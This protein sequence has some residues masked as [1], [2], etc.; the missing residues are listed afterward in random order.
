MKLLVI[1]HDDEYCIIDEKCYMLLGWWK[2]WYHVRTNELKLKWKEMTSLKHSKLSYIPVGTLYY[3]ESQSCY[4]QND[5]LRGW[6]CFPHYMLYLELYSARP[7]ML[8]FCYVMVWKILVNKL[9]IRFYMAGY[10]I[11]NLE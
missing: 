4:I 2:L 6:Y 3:C 1:T 5:Y 7:V 10:P 11:R 9:Y 8:E